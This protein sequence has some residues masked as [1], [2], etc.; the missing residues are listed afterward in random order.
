MKAKFHKL[1]LSVPWTEENEDLNIYI[2]S[3]TLWFYYTFSENDNN[4]I[5]RDNGAGSY[6]D[7]MDIWE[8]IYRQVE[9]IKVQ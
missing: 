7:D 2:K 3:N 1:F 4:L 9:L 5:L 8:S 6:Y